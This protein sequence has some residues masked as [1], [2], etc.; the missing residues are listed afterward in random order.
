M[1]A[2]DP[3]AY[4]SFSIYQDTESPEFWTSYFGVTPDTQR[5]KGEFRVTSSSQMSKLPARIGMWSAN[6]K[7]HVHSDNLEP[8]LRYLALKRASVFRIAQF[9]RSPCAL[10]STQVQRLR[11]CS[12]LRDGQPACRFSG[13]AWIHACRQLFAGFVAPFARNCQRHVGVHAE[14][15]TFSFPAKRYFK[16]HH[17]PPLGATSR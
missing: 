3:L 11:R 7:E 14:R 5:I 8:H 13:V 10:P 6:S 9:R 16:R 4:A 15:N 2:K 12:L 17:L 1:T